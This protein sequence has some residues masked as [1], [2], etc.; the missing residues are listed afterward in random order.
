M[1]ER[2]RIVLKGAKR[3]GISLAWNLAG[4]YQE[5][6]TKV[7]SIHMATVE[8]CA[9]AYVK[10]P[11]PR[12]ITPPHVLNRLAAIALA[13]LHIQFRGSFAP[14]GSMEIMK[15]QPRPRRGMKMMKID[16]RSAR[17]RNNGFGPGATIGTSPSPADPVGGFGIL[18]RRPGWSTLDARA[19]AHRAL[20]SRV[21]T[22][23]ARAR[24]QEPATPGAAPGSPASR[25]SRDA[26]E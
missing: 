4:G 10:E 26:V 20:G 23:R 5:P 8:E 19:Q 22:T 24:A 9:R 15:D 25:Q 14:R 11:A 17:G 21:W 18:S 12:L 16:P 1:H 3:A 6:L 13:V 7:I 2:D